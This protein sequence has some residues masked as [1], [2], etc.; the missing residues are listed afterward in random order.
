MISRITA[1][2]AAAGL[3]VATFA[4]FTAPGL[5]QGTPPVATPAPAPQPGVAARVRGTINSLTGNV[6]NVTTREGETINITL[7]AEYRVNA[8]VPLTLD[9]IT[10][11]AYVGVVADT[12]AQG[13]LVAL[14]VRVFPEA[15]RGTGAGSRPWDLTP[16][17]SMNNGTLAAVEPQAQGR[18][19]RVTYPDG[20]KLVMIGP[21]T[22]IWSTEPGDASLVVP[23]AYVVINARKLDDGSYTAT[24]IMIEKNGTRPTL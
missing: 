4:S 15:N 19:V 12:D 23:G 18:L 6:L 24:N 5:A 11:N 8:A 13:N 17:S 2:V 21:D 9:D 3:A 7:A 1:F 14:D 16:T 20:E 22:P 10:N